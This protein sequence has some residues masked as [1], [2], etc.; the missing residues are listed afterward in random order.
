MIRR[1][2]ARPASVGRRPQ[3][4]ATGTPASTN[5]R[6]FF[7]YRANSSPSYRSSAPGRIGNALSRSAIRAHT[8]RPRRLRPK[9]RPRNSAALV[10]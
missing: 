2:A 8:R 9:F 3:I 10:G 7:A 1:T 6:A 5:S 4:A